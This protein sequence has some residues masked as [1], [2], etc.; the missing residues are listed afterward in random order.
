MPED[1]EMANL[2]YTS[3]KTRDSGSFV[4]QNGQFDNGP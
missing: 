1:L 2:V 3:I 4:K